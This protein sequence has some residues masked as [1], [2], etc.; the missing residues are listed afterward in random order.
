[1]VKSLFFFGLAAVL[2][3]VPT[4]AQSVSQN[5]PAPT[6]VL[7]FEPCADYR[8]GSYEQISEYL[9][10]LDQASERIQ[11][12]NIG[13]TTEGRTQLMAVISSAANMRRLPHFKS[14]SRRLALANDLTPKEAQ[15]LAIDARSVV[16]IDFGL[17]S[18]EVAHAQ[19]APQLAY[20]AVTD[21]SPEM[22][23]IRDNV[24]LL[25]LPNMNPDG[26]SLVANWYASHVGTPYERASPVELYQ[27]Y[28]GHDNNR[29]W[30][31]FNLAESRN[32]A[33]QLYR[34]WFPQIVY[35]HHQS[36]PFPARIFVPPFIDP[37]NPNIPPLVMRGINLAGESISRRLEQEGKTGVIS[38]INYDTW[39]N[40]G[41]RT[42]AYYHNMVGILTETSH[43]WANP[44]VHDASLFPDTFSNGRSTRT[45]S[46]DYPNPYRGGEWHLKDSCNYMLTASMAV[47]DLGAQRRTEWTYDMY[48]MG[49]QSIK[50]GEG[51]LY[52]VSQNQWDLG[53]AIKLVNTLRWGGIEIE[54]TTRSLRIGGVD[55]P[56]NSFIIRGAQSFRPYLTDL[57]NPQAYP[58][59]R[60]RP[61]GPLD[62]PYDIT[63]WTLPMQMGVT[64]DRHLDAGRL[65]T[66]AV[67]SIDRAVLMSTRLKPSTGFA[68]ALDP[69][70]NDAF[71][72]INRLLTNDHPVYRTTS[73]ITL[74]THTWPAGTFIL[75][76]QSETTAAIDLATKGL[77]L[78]VSPVE[79]KPDQPL[80]QLT[81]P[82]V[83]L[84]RSW[85]PNPDEGWT[86][87][88]LEEFGFPY[89]RLLNEDMRNG[90]FNNLDVILLPD[91]TY[92]QILNGLGRRDTPPAYQGGITQKGVSHLYDFVEAGGILVAF[93]SASALPL[94]DF[95]LPI[96]DIST[97][98]SA[99]DYYVPGSL[100]E[101]IVN[102]THPIGYG[103]P[104]RVPGFFSRS[105]VF[106]LASQKD[107]DN[108]LKMH[109]Q[110]VS[111]V[112]QYPETNMLLSGWMVGEKLLA[113]KAAIVEAKLGRGKVVLLGLRAQHRGQTH[114]TYK[115]LFNS[116]FLKAFS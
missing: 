102:S 112:A 40:G 105:P 29:D 37:M 44:S 7:G 42:A 52:V 32:V 17:H 96:L 97:N 83:G 93:D 21:E 67:V 41:M 31:M 101:I 79:R 61:G 14:A 108:S 3:N 27:R 64:V 63:G 89:R 95:E 1:M 58:D 15:E 113:N 5:I 4:V 78:V 99:N 16:W 26:T 70:R 34:E 94:A 46:T 60:Q 116:L 13:Q 2:A 45:P 111:I 109:D 87:L 12:V 55:Y 39:W 48:R 110:N 56:P 62:R 20:H 98:Y 100:L 72:A 28:A 6:S 85:R 10:V 54:Q 51:E 22:Q 66:N 115:L 82:Q 76:I 49:R 90:N 18:T 19:V 104:A 23:A 35:N 80:T 9:Q 30:F 57:L 107:S 47:L 36:A 81:Q 77:G 86:R 69:R 24:I 25:L 59:T 53:A 43:P 50:A 74:E 103:M 91:A 11:L 92:T 8:L 88:V 75:P 71:L 84:Y 33:T 114:G 106:S 65:P 73:P 68:Y 38:R